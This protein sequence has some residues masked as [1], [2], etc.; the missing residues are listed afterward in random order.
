LWQSFKRSLPA[1]VFSSPFVFPFQSRAKARNETRWDQYDC[2][3]YHELRKRPKP[4]VSNSIR[5]DAGDDDC[6]RCTRSKSKADQA[7]MIR[8]QNAERCSYY[9]C[10]DEGGKPSE[11]YRSERDP[12]RMQEKADRDTNAD[13]QRNC[14]RR[15]PSWQSLT[16]P[17]G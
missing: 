1:V 10:T 3:H 12:S 14:T 7:E 8:R 17:V 5:Y 2:E 4:V 16:P 11:Q 15:A 13:G 9:N 6:Q